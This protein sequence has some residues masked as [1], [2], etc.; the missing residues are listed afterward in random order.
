MNRYAKLAVMIVSMPV[1]A[2]LTVTWLNV[3]ENLRPTN[4]RSEFAELKRPGALA[5]RA[6][7]R[8]LPDTAMPTKISELDSNASS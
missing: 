7:R 6:V 8:S 4:H 5:V 3:R 2:A 1:V